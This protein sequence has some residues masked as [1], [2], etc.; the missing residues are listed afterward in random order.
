MRRPLVVTLLCSCVLA[1]AACGDDE[2]TVGGGGGDPTAATTAATET[3]QDTGTTGSGCEP[4]KKPKAKKVGKQ[5]RTSLK[6]DTSKRYTAVLETNC[7]PIEI[8]LDVKRAPKTSASFMALARKGFFD[9]LGFHRI[10]PGFVVQ[11]GD[12]AGTGNGGPGYDVV[13]TPPSDL[14][15]T[16]GVVAMAK[17]EMDAPGTSGSQFFIVTADDAGLPPDYALLGKV[18]KGMDAVAKIEAVPAEADG[19]PTEPV[20][21]SKVS[22]ETK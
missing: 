11:G 20:V 10:V 6:V 22:I 1:L 19:Q 13:E 15:Y 18:T 9:G 8:A 5:K 12:P 17:T 2:E 7:G 16:K 21:M 3:Q 14:K 4:A